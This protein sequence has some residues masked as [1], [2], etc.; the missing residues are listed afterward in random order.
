MESNII[1]ETL[2]EPEEPLSI[3]F[4]NTANAFSVK[5]DKELLDTY[6]IF[7]LM[8]NE[9]LVNLG[10]KL[11]LMAIKMKLPFAKNIIKN[12]MFKI[13]CGGETLLDCQDTIEK[14][15][16]YNTLTVLD[17]GAEGKNTEE[18]LN[19]VMEEILRSIDLAASNSSV[20]VVVAKLSGLA[21]NRL[22]EDMSSMDEVDPKHQHLYDQFIERIDTICSRAAEHGVGI[23]IDAE[24]SWIQDGIDDVA[25]SLM[26]KYNKGSVIVYN[27]YQM[28]RHD[29]LAQLKQDHQDGLAEGYMIGAKIVR[30]A[31]MDKENK[32]AQEKGYPT[33]IQPNKAAT[34]RDYDAAV[35]YCVRNYETISSCCATHNMESSKKQAQL[36]HDL[37]IPKDHKHLNF[38][39]LYGM[40]DYI[41]FNIADAG[42]NV[43]KYIP[44]GPIEE[45][46]PYLIRRAEENTSITGEMNRELKLI[47]EEV[48]RRGLK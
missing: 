22:L 39:Q 16:K 4:S 1:D 13:F 32:R 3:D 15:Y 36:I 38:S 25:I 46:I 43:A 10:S 12:T 27:T 48:Q 42:Y 2:P 41:T 29:K 35:E 14:L 18:E 20:P 33:P 9:T 47:K 40:S 31:Y 11:G 8:N 37:K 28:Y 24:E 17:Y 44:Y 45:V 19:E 34:D 26:K 23:F 30:G 7:R 21:K 5:S 6:K